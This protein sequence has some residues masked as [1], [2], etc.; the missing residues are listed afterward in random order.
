MLKAMRAM[1]VITA[2]AIA[3]V[4]ALFIWQAVDIYLTGNAPENFTAAGVRIEPVYARADVARRI[5]AIAPALWALLAIV[6]ADLGLNAACDKKGRARALKDPE[7]DVRLLRARVSELPEGCEAERRRRRAVRLTAGFVCLVCAAVSGAYLLDPADFSSTDLEAVMGGVLLHTVPW[8]AL[9]LVSI[10]AAGVLCGRS[11][12]R[13][14]ALLKAAPKREDTQT[15]K[16][17]R[18]APWRAGLYAAAVALIVLGVLNGGLWDVLV[19][20]I[21]ICTECIGLG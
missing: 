14:L 8:A 18:L 20:A 21:N 19:K 4:C 3:A 9:A 13:E 7:E 5:G 12:E 16:K 11:A 1:R 2:V 15:P 10:G 6:A 17:R